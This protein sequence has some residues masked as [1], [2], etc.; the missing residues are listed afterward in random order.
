MLCRSRRTVG[1]RAVRSHLSYR[2]ARAASRQVA[3]TGPLLL[4]R[5]RSLVTPP[6]TSS[7]AWM[8]LHL[9]AHPG[10]GQRPRAVPRIAALRAP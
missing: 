2:S 1:R 7:Q 6:D 5:D 4:A 10:L 8:R 3:D 9:C